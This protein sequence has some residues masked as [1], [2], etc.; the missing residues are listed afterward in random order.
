MDN[1]L[2]SSAYLGKLTV[3]QVKLFTF[4]KG[5]VSREWHG[6]EK[7]S[8]QSNNVKRESLN[9]CRSSRTRAPEEIWFLVLFAGGFKECF[10]SHREFGLS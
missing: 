8:V 7:H 10:F 5:K 6:L 3:T 2:T 9:S 1:F 4:L